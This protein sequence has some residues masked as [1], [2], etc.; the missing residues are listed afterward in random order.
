MHDMKKHYLS[1]NIFV[2]LELVV[3]SLGNKT[4]FILTNDHKL[5][6]FSILNLLSDLLFYFMEEKLIFSES[7]N[8]EEIINLMQK[9]CMLPKD[10]EKEDSKIILR[11]VFQSMELLIRLIDRISDLDCLSKFFE[12]NPDFIKNLNETKNKNNYL[13]NIKSF[14]M[15]LLMSQE[16]NLEHLDQNWS[17]FIWISANEKKKLLWFPSYEQ[18]IKNI[19]RLMEYEVVEDYL[20]WKEILTLYFY[21][22]KFSHFFSKNEE[23]T[24]TNILQKS[25]LVL[26]NMDNMEDAIFNYEILINN[27]HFQSLLKNLINFLIDSFNKNNNNE[28]NLDKFIK[29]FLKNNNFSDI[30]WLIE[31][32]LSSNIMTISNSFLEEICVYCLNLAKNTS[33]L[34]YILNIFLENPK[35]LQIQNSELSLTLFY[36]LL[37]LLF[38]GPDSNLLSLLKLIN[39]N[40]IQQLDSYFNE[41]LN[42][43]LFLLKKEEKEALKYLNERREDLEWRENMRIAVKKNFEVFFL[44]FLNEF[45]GKVEKKFEKIKLEDLNTTHLGINE[46]ISCIEE[47]SCQIYLENFF[48][49]EKTLSQNV[50]NSC[51]NGSKKGGGYKIKSRN[52]NFGMRSLLTRSKQV[53][54]IEPKEGIAKSNGKNFNFSSFNEKQELD[55]FLNLDNFPSLSIGNLIKINFFFSLKIFI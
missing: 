25:F 28:Q 10:F 7:N 8:N 50:L 9:L 54:S 2:L 18:I 34:T 30:T 40:N 31:K 49:L 15:E 19:D 44:T 29:L 17:F 27:D 35:I 16:N 46:Y 41:Q 39:N 24:L 38:S 53:S 48:I 20:N 6:Y 42:E 23:K 5:N 47:E 33:D 1:K 3:E 36:I 43:I 37:N 21:I 12:E 32:V 45:P 26:K 22:E 52:G 55:D 11:L 51:Y 14:L 4:N 13:Y